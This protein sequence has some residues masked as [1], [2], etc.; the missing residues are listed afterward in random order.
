MCGIFGYVGRRNDAGSLVI[1]G[2]KNLEY[3]GYDSWGVACKTNSKVSIEK[4]I[5]K[6]SGVKSEDFSSDCSLAIG[7]TRWATHG[8]V[9]RQNAH[10]HANSTETIAVVHNG[11]LENYQ[12]LKKIWNQ[13]GTNLS[14][15]LIQRLFLI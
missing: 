13:K 1:D 4:D 11:I 2:L 10:P 9:T 14:Q 6:I 15:K 8:G 12:Q 7:H 3:R 5:G